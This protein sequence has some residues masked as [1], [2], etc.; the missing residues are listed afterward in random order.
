MCTNFSIFHIRSYRN[1][2]IVKRCI[3]PLHNL[4]SWHRFPWNWIYFACFPILHFSHW[5]CYFLRRIMCKIGKQ[6]SEEHTS[7][8]QSRFDLVCRL[9]LDKTTTKTA[10]GSCTE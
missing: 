5:L 2:F 6:R 1:V 10:M 3:I 7:E 9:L 8:L 4:H